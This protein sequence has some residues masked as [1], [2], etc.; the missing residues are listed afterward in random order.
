MAQKWHGNMGP[1]DSKPILKGNA[2]ITGVPTF[3]KELPLTKGG[4]AGEDL[5]FGRVVSIDPEKNRREFVLGWEEGQIVQGIVML[6]PSQMIA[7]PGM[8]QYYF[9]GRPMTITTMGL[10]DILEYDVTKS[11]PMEGSTVW[12]RNSDGMLAFNDG[13]DISGDGY[14]KLNAYVY[15]SLDPNGAK[16]WFGI[17]FVTEQTREKTVK[18]A[19]PV[20][21]PVAGAVQAGSFVEIESPDGGV[22]YYT[23]DGTVPN[24]KSLVYN[25]PISIS[26]AVT[27]KA[28]AVV[29]GKDPS[30]VLSAEYTIKE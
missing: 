15:E 13:T 14:T 9:A 3:I 8:P 21:S 16:V 10:I 27:I 24:E 30:Q 6:S 23:I 5:P 17:P 4:I 11:T 2:H 18:A 7:D 1:F 22:I 19:T 12:F 29:P 20:A 28:L 26:A 25:G